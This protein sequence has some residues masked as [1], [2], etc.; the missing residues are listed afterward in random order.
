ME[1]RVIKTFAVW[2]QVFKLLK[3]ACPRLSIA[4]AVLTAL[5]AVLALL[6]RETVVHRLRVGLSHAL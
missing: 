5:E 6:P 2:T 1:G 3:R 4:V